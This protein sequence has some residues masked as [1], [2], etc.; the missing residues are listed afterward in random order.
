MSIE[1]VKIPV[2]PM[3]SIEERTI[4][5]TPEQSDG[6][7]LSKCDHGWSRDSCPIC[8]PVKKKKKHVQKV[9]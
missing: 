3:E 9:R 6:I 7:N 4:F 2:W 1:D 5:D 8:S